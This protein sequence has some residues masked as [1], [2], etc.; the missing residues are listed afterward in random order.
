MTQVHEPTVA[1]KQ[2]R[3]RVRTK[4]LAQAN[5]LPTVETTV[6]AEMKQSP[7]LAPA[8]MQVRPTVRTLQQVIASTQTSTHKS[9]VVFVSGPFSKPKSPLEF[10]DKNDFEEFEWR[11]GL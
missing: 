9:A 5:S 2:S 3:I 4:P 1:S 6:A 11:M 10:P 7:S 8:D